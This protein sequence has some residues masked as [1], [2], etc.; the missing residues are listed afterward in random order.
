MDDDFALTRLTRLTGRGRSATIASQGR[1]VA[2]FGRL[3]CLSLPWPMADC[4]A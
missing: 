2:R 4:L 1:V 3:A